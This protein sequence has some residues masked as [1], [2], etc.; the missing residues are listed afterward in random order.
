[1]K[2]YQ[3]LTKQALLH[4][5]CGAILSPSDMMDGRVV[6]LEALDKKGSNKE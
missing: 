1:M 2:L 5:K 4:A 3:F 6:K